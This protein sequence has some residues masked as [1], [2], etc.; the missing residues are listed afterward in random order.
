MTKDIESI[1]SILADARNKKNEA[2]SLENLNNLEQNKLIFLENLDG[3]QDIV[4]QIDSL[5]TTS[6][7]INAKED[8]IADLIFEN[9][10]AEY[11]VSL[12]FKDA[13]VYMDNCIDA[14][15]GLT[16][17][18]NEL[19]VLNEDLEET[20]SLQEKDDL[21]LTELDDKISAIKS[22]NDEYEA[23]MTKNNICLV[24]GK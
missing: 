6:E 11:F 5:K 18:Q 19:A 3:I 7:D 12:Q 16:N 2:N 23:Y 20:N 14:I 4:N 22:E 10:Q 21:S 17:I 13:I 15:T 24:C 1:K 8:K 9:T